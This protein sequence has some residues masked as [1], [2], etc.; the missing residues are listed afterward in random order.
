MKKNE[1]YN[2][3][4][5]ESNNTTTIWFSIDDSK[6]PID[7]IIDNLNKQINNPESDLRSTFPNIDIEYGIQRF[8]CKNL[9]ELN[10]AKNITFLNSQ[11]SKYPNEIKVC[12]GD[13]CTCKIVYIKV[14]QNIIPINMRI[15]LIH[16]VPIN[17]TQFKELELEMQNIAEDPK[18][19]LNKMFP[20]FMQKTM[21][22]QYLTTE[23]DKIKNENAFNEYLK[24]D[25]KWH[26]YDDSF[27]QTDEAFQK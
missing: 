16:P 7:E 17:F 18:S 12:N 5:M 25:K 27:F 13:K 3:I 4:K 8:N 2:I 20:Q 23:F 24:L 10:E 15:I 26:Y 1:K 21:S 22:L 6:Q 19:D 14:N 11:I 9:K